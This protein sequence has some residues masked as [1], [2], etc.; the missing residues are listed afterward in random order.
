MGQPSDEQRHGQHASLARAALLDD[1]VALAEY[2]G[3]LL[4]LRILPDVPPD[5]RDAT[6]RLAAVLVPLYARDGR[7]HLLFTRRSPQLTSHSGEI[8]FP[9]G[10]HD[11][12]DRT[13]AT[14]A[15]RE[16]HEEIGL[17]PESVS[18]LGS[19][20]PVFTVVSNFLITPIVGWLGATP[21]PLVP[22]P[23]EVVEVIEAPLA[24]LADPSIFHAEEWIRNG[25]PHPVYF[26]D[27]GPYRI[28]GATARVLRDLLELLPGD[29]H[30]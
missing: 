14:T 7:P 22:N 9:G 15:L 28:W 3:Q 26:Y 30:G 5:A 29:E 4:P 12:T 8:S 16:A 24:D 1:A 20:A 13:L 25:R 2:L 23:A 10:S 18:V 17:A 6:P 19:L 21:A 11:A 27:L